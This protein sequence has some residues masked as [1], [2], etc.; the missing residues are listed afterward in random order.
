M[1]RRSAL[2]LLC[3]IGLAGCSS[4]NLSKTQKPEEEESK[5]RP[6]RLVGDIAVPFGE[7]PVS[8]EAV[9][10]VTGLHGTG[11]DPEPSGQRADALG[12]NATPRR[13]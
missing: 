12:R 11:S 2:V 9:G 7:F 3:V 13:E 4:W 8:I 1:E 6:E 10:L 5:D